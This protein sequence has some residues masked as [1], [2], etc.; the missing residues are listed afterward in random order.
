MGRVF[1]PAPFCFR[2]FLR[3][4]QPLRPKG[5][6][7][8]SGDPPPVLAARCFAIAPFFNPLASAK[9][10]PRNAVNEV[11]GGTVST[12]NASYSITMRLHYLNQV[13]MFSRIAAAI[14]E[15]GGDVG[16]IDI[17]SVTSK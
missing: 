5:P 6:V 17:V 7:R 11:G 10:A 8:R 15:A 14:S 16:A 12:P 4:S 3:Q 2:T 1:G 9:V 13:G